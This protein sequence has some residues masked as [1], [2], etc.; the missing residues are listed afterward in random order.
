MNKSILAFTFVIL[1]LSSSLAVHSVY[2]T[3]GWMNNPTPKI[4]HS[5]MNQ[6]GKTK[7]CGDHLC[8]PFEN[9]DMKKTLNIVQNKQN[10]T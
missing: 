3:K 2:A 10:T 9:N 7:V 8:K 1:L 6:N 4:S 5:T